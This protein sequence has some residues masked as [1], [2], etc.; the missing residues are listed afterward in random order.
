MIDYSFIGLK[1]NIK[2]NDKSVIVLS[3]NINENDKANSANEIIDNTE[4]NDMSGNIQAST[5]HIIMIRTL[6]LEMSM[7]EKQ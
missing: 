3:G 4:V 6:M 7:L 1:P 5:Y 2:S